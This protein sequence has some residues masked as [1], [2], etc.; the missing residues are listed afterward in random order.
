MYSIRIE[1]VG[2]VIWIQWLR[3]L[4]TFYTNYN[5]LFMRFEL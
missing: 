4:G 5:D 2:V 3:T 1:R